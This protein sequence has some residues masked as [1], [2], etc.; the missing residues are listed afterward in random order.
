MSEGNVNRRLTSI[1]AADMVGYSR[2]M[3][4]D[5]AG[6]LAW[7]KKLRKELLDPKAVQYGGRTVKL[8]GDGTLMEFSS[9]V[10]AVQFAVDVQCTLR[11]RNRDLDSKQRIEFRVGINIGDII[12]D[13]DDI[14]GEGVNVAARLENLSPPGGICIS[15]T[16]F[17]HVKGKLDLTF[18][19]RGEQKVKN[20]ADPV[21]AYDIELDDLARA[22]VTP[23]SQ[24][25]V[26]RSRSLGY[27][28]AAAACVALLIGAGMFWYQPGKSPQQS[29]AAADLPPLPSGPKIAIVPFSNL[30]GDDE[31]LQLAA[32]ISEDIATTL[33][34]FS[35]LFIFSLSATVQYQ[36]K[37]VDPRRIGEELGAQYVL[38]GSVRRS[39]TNLRVVAK[40]LDARDAQH[41]WS[42]TYDRDLSASSIYTVLDEVTE[43]VVATL[44]SNDG[45]IRLQ[46]AQR[47][48]SRR[49]DS[50]EAY[51]CTARSA[52]YSGTLNQQMREEIRTCLERA[53]KLSPNYS[54]AWS[55]LANFLIETYKNVTFSEDESKT[56][57]E[58]ADAAAKKAIEIDNSNETAYYL[59][60]IVSQLRKEGYEAFKALADKAL[61][62]NPNNGL[63]VG[64]IGNFSF[65]SGDFERGKALVGRMMKINPRYP[66]WAHFVFFLD[67]YRNAEYPEALREVLKITAPTHCMVQWSKAAAYGKVGETDKGMATLQHIAA[68]DPPCPDEPREPFRKRGFPDELVESILDG[69]H[70][71]GLKSP[72]TGQ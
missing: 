35:D 44:G 28:L 64:D 16:V 5:E 23:V 69:L 18:A 15:R 26:R 63:V 61:A 59:R 52:L 70:R 50:L 9:V 45:V 36:G 62:A 48:L 11:D 29:V 13:G 2:M 68:I 54:K 21:Q 38:D 72:E 8:M 66:S 65:Y 46:E 51:Q 19:D 57:L 39:S 32:G 6:T 4:E 7:L 53:V 56:L 60:A 37:S 55:D 30:G 12:V 34:R 10:D 58:R 41:L 31:N 43:G 22:L 67:H 24:Q 27:L 71:A 3:G 1:L 42:Q 17:N 25:A 14:Y 20:I 47:V 49:T 40:L 33:S